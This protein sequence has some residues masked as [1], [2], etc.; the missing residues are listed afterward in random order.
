MKNLIKKITVTG[1]VFALIFACSS[2]SSAT[3]SETT[4]HN[5]FCKHTDSDKVPPCDPSLSFIEKHGGY[6]VDRKV[7]DEKKVIYLTFDAGYENG[8]VEK[9]VDVLKEKNVTGAFFVLEN[10][11][12]T[13]P[14]LMKKMF[15]NGDLI[16]NHTSKHRD[17]TSC[18]S[19]ED[20]EKE[21]SGLEATLRE[22]TGIEMSKFYR[23]PEGRFSERDL[24]WADE[25][26]YKSV[27]WSFAYADWDNA[28][29][30]DPDKAIEKILKNTHNGEIILL[31]PTSSTN[32]AILGR[33][34]DSWKEMGYSFGS[35]NDL[36]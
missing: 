31:H 25:L 1:I 28:K 27:F 29:Q 21:L 7:S 35:L 16:C 19:K 12:R 6:Y 36:A 33:L 9:I 13:N 10:I 20:F 5:W 2:E 15:E 11:I 17:M 8:N 30:P 26:G 34:I 32:A 24:K 3:A 22:V 4:P 23:P 14:D 18:S